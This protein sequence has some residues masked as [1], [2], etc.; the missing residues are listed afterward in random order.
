MITSTFTCHTFYRKFSI[1][2]YKV[3]TQ[4]LTPSIHYS[5]KVA[6][7]KEFVCLL[8]KSVD[9]TTQ[10][11]A[12]EISC[13]GSSTIKG[14][15]SVVVETLVDTRSDHYSLY[16]QRASITPLSR[17]HI[18][19]FAC[20]GSKSIFRYENT[21]HTILFITIV[22][23]KANRSVRYDKHRIVSIKT[24]IYHEI[25]IRYDHRKW[26]TRIA[27]QHRIPCD[28]ISIIVVNIGIVYMKIFFVSIGIFPVIN[29]LCR[30]FV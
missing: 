29:S 18:S 8:R 19:I 30:N 6:V 13:S 24:T 10:R 27:T 20:C 4:R 9:F 3:S 12:V 7:V 28:R 2:R 22:I 14:R 1:I 17:H 16:L 23:F 15:T 21:L 25:S 26:F 11:I 5:R